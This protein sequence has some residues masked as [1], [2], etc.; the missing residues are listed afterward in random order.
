MEQTHVDVLFFI[1]IYRKKL[2][3][4]ANG[5]EF[6]GAKKPGRLREDPSVANGS[7]LNERL[8]LLCGQLLGS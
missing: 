1:P 3:D 4:P 5:K 2:T 7:V 6:N 8:G